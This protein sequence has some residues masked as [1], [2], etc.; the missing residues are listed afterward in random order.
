M[1]S[2]EQKERAEVEELRHPLVGR[3]MTKGGR[4]FTITDVLQ[5]DALKPVLL[6]TYEHVI[7]FRDDQG[8]QRHG[9]IKP[10]ATEAEI[11]QELSDHGYSLLPEDKTA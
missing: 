4:I 10:Y 11:V 9:E 1:T 5:H 8:M 2:P 3:K 7:V 6:P